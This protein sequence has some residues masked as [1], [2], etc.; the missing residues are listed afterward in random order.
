MN[1][2]LFLFLT[3]TLAV[4]I[5]SCSRPA[6]K[7]DGSDSS[8]SGSSAE[9]LPNYAVSERNPN[10]N[11]EN[12]DYS[13]LAP[14]TVHFDFDSFAI[15]ASE[16]PKLEQAAKWISD[17]P[18]AKLVL[19]GHTDSRGTTQ[20]NLALGERRSLATRDYL[21]GLG[22]DNSRMTTISY[23]KERPA[24]QG[25]NESAWTANRRCELGVAR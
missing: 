24:Q 19:A 20:Y 18:N 15:K 23:G 21:L 16:R 2:K 7:D 22:V 12:A 6:K 4:V 1:P 10:I 25:E 8:M 17:N 11:P 5:S 13:Q 3:L 9:G 14:Y